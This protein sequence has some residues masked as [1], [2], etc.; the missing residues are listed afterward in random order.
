MSLLGFTRFEAISPDKDGELDLDV[1][2]A[3]LAETVTWL[4]RSKTVAKVSFFPSRPRRWID[5]SRVPASRIGDG[6]SWRAGEHGP[7]SAI[8]PKT[9]F[10]DW[11]MSCS[12]LSRTC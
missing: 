6:S 8:A 10:P 12:T 11:P 4:L 2:R 7:L 5:G 1:I 9:G 3:S